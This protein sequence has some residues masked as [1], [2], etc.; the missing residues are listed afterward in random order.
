MK[1]DSEANKILLTLFV[2]SKQGWKTKIPQQRR[3]PC[4]QAKDLNLNHNLLFNFNFKSQTGKLWKTLVPSCLES[5]AQSGVWIIFFTGIIQFSSLSIYQLLFSD[6]SLISTII[7]NIL[8]PLEFSRQ[9]GPNKRDVL[10]IGLPIVLARAF[11]QKN[12]ENI[13]F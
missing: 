1:I 10:R 7:T 6:L 3:K 4:R 12:G 8:K 11:R 2:C 13:H 9:N 5:S